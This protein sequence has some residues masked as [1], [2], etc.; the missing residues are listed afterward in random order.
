M[1]HTD[2]VDYY[3]E[4]LSSGIKHPHEKF[5][6]VENMKRF[7]ELEDTLNVHHLLQIYF[8]AEVFSSKS[9]LLPVLQPFNRPNEA[10]QSYYKY[11]KITDTCQGK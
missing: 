6:P 8:Y 2:F 10:C 4:L 3:I 5:S 7:K 11:Q 1:R 9:S